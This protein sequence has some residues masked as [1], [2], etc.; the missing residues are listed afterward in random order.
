MTAMVDKIGDSTV[1]D[2]ISC[3][4]SDYNEHNNIRINPDY[5]LHCAAVAYLL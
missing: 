1:L 5:F 2:N 4:T 3:F